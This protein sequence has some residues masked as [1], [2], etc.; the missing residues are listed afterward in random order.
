MVSMGTTVVGAKRPNLVLRILD[1]V[2]LGGVEAVGIMVAI[3]M[4]L[5]TADVFLRYVFNSPIKGNYELQTL[6]MVAVVFFGLAWAQSKRGHIRMDV[7]SSRFSPTIQDFLN[8]LGD[9]IFLMIAGIITWQ[10]AINGW[11]AFLSGDYLYGLIK[12]PVWPAKLAMVLGSGLVSLQLISGIILNPL[13]RYQK[14]I[15]RFKYFLLIA[16]VVFFFFVLVVLSLY[17]NT[18]DLSNPTIGWITIGIFL[19]LLMIGTPVAPSL[20][21]MGIYGMWQ[22]LSW[23]AAMGTAVT[24]PYEA[25]SNYTMTTLPMFII[26]GSFADLAGFGKYGF[27]LARVWLDRVRGGIIYATIAGATAFAASCGSSIASLSVLTKVAYPPMIKQGVR[28]DM[29]IGVITVS[30]LLAPM[31]PPS[32]LFIVYGMLTQASIG[33][34]LMAGIIPGL[35]GAIMIAIS[36]YLRCKFDPKIIYGT[37]LTKS[38]WKE[39][40]VAVPRAWGII[41]IALVIIGGI[42]SGVFTPT[43]AGAVGAFAACIAMLVITKWKLPFVHQSLKDCGEISANVLF[44]LVGGMTFGY[45]VS[46]TQLPDFLSTWVT[47]LTLPSIVIL[48]CIMVMYLILG[49]FV[50]TLSTMIITLPIVLPIITGMGFSPIWFGVLM[51]QN[52]ELGAVTPPFGLNLFV[53]RGLLPDTSL[54]EIIKAASFFILPLLVTMAIYIAFPQVCLWLPNMMVK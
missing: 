26:L 20:A 15:S 4:V 49:C 24:A 11:Q 52:A 8:L 36:V 47:S 9:V 48:I 45:M 23:G 18:L 16:G 6:M 31:I 43:E 42:Y 1:K 54:G 3:M 46:V 12:F 27:E 41:F 2:E 53:M 22:M 29:A 14:G 32:G 40:F 10:M 33:Q 37:T 21:L 25:S 5:T 35:I 50:D 28:K 30:S 44:I 17:L 51:V 38:T 7:F 34:L 13:W 39:R 19:I